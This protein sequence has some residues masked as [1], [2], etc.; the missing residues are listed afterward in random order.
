MQ[1]GDL[2]TLNLG[3]VDRGIGIIT[4]LNGTDA[5]GRYIVFWLKD[6]VQYTYTENSLHLWKESTKLTKLLFRV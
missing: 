5:L 1:V 3:K 2:V 6:N 4:A